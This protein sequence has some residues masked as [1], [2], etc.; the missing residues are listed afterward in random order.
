M[1]SFSPRQTLNLNI[2][3][4]SNIS[5]K[6]NACYDFAYS[7]D[8]QSLS[9]IPTAEDLEGPSRPRTEERLWASRVNA[10]RSEKSGK[11]TQPPRKVWRE[12][13]GKWAKK[14]MAS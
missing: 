10:E 8:M 7:D 11:Q 2:R 12:M 4:P 1:T 13:V 14:M 6:N 9:Q 3:I 5:H